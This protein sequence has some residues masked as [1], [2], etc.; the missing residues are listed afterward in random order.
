MTGESAITT[1]APAAVLPSWQMD[2]NILQLV[3]NVRE[4][5]TPRPE[6]RRH[7]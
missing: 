4:I 2:Q 1:P 6:A 3:D 5:G 7:L